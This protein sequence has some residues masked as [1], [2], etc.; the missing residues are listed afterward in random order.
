[1]EF[2]EPNVAVVEGR[3]TGGGTHGRGS[4]SLDRCQDAI[5]FASGFARGRRVS[6]R[7]GSRGIRKLG[8]EPDQSAPHGAIL[9]GLGRFEKA[10]RVAKPDFIVFTLPPH[11]DEKSYE[12]RIYKENKI[13]IGIE[14]DRPF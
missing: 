2:L 1:V 13:Y 9:S 11:S 12:Y 8:P 5:P 4:P 10:S 3:L 14:L 6:S 7:H